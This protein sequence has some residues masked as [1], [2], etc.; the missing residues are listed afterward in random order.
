MNTGPFRRTQV[1]EN[2]LKGMIEPAIRIVRIT[3]TTQ[4]FD[5]ASDYP[6]NADNSV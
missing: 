2:L 3:P 4:V 6:T 1:R 5:N